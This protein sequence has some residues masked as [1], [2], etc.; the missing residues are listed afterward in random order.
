VTDSQTLAIDQGTHSTR[1]AVYDA[2]GRMLALT[3]R[4]V[5]LQTHSRTQV[6]QSPAQILDSLH[7]VMEEIL[8][9]PGVEAAR[10]GSAGLATQRSSV[11]AW[12]SRSGLPLSPVLS[13]QDTR[14]A[15]SLEALVRYEDSI[16]ER[17][18]L[19]LSAHYGAGKLQWLL[20]H[21]AAVAA[22]RGQGT[23]AIGP[24]ASFLLHHMVVDTRE[25]VDH[26]NASRTLLW[27]LD[28]RDWDPWLLGLFDIP[29][30]ALP[31]CMPVLADYGMTRHGSIPLNAVNGDQTAA[32]YA[33]GTPDRDTLLVNT[34]TGAFVLLPIGAQQAPLSRLLRGLSRSDACTADHYLEGT[35][36]GAAAALDWMAAQYGIADWPAQLGGWLDSNDTPPVFLN[37]V[38]GLGAP[39]W[40]TGPEPVLLYDAAG[41][42]TG[43]AQA[44]VAVIESIVFLIQTN[45]ELLCAHNP[46]VKCIRIAGGLAPL[47]GL[48]RKLANLSG[49][50]VERSHA[51]EATLRG[52]AWLAA[53]SP[54]TWA[55][56]ETERRFLPRDDP[57][58]GQRYGRFRD[59]LVSRLRQAP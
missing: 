40:Q 46:R 8:R 27:N 47:D 30:E 37:S 56:I 35:V 49:L 17:T 51:I 16:R 21:E 28:D 15:A 32:L 36:N 39:W 42:K 13:W 4:A 44:M 23:L 50:A 58:L 48:C 55:S 33:G 43:P 9:Q 2:R 10:I 12:E 52:I 38:G 14:A 53:G 3:R 1:A 54:D 20:R 59:A 34:G 41:A 29:R 22:A 5:S 31:D 26:A 25:L 6:E 24:L 45:I 11:L 19:R 57:G 7:G 18:G